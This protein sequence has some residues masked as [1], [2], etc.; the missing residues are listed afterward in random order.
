MVVVVSRSQI[1][2]AKRI[3]KK[4]KISSWEIGSVT[5]RKGVVLA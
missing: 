4:H 3:L 2:K 5:K 1:G